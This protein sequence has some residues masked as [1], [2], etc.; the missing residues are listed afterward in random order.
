MKLVIL[1]IQT[2]SPDDLFINGLSDL[3]EAVAYGYTSPDLIYERCKDA[4]MILTNKTVI[5]RKLMEQLP[6]LRYIGVLATGYNVVDIDAAHERGIVV[7]NIPSYSTMS[8]AQMVWAHLL[9]IVNRVDYYAQQNREGRWCRNQDFCY[10]DFPH[11]ELDGKVFGIVGTGNIGRAVARIAEAF[12]MRVIGVNSKNMNQLPD[13][14]RESDVVSLHCVLNDKT[15]ELINSDT[16]AL[17]KQSAILINTGR[18]GLINEQ[19]VADALNQGRIAAYAADVL[20]VEPPSADNPLFQAKNSY[21]T[22]HIAWATVEARQRLLHIAID[23][24]RTFLNG[25]ERNNV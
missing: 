20:S 9:N 1:D 16:L 25:E 22:P 17:M 5:D 8:V 11:H 21:L 19:D 4:E 2:C 7:T 3:V 24:I 23:N 10:Y 14:L 15:K 13:L 6:R 12:G 18:G